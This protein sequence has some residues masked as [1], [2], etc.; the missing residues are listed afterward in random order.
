MGLLSSGSGPQAPSLTVSGSPVQVSA[1]VNNITYTPQTGYYGADT[2]N[3]TVVRASLSQITTELINIRVATNPIWVP[4]AGPFAVAELS[5]IPV[6]F[7]LIVSGAFDHSC[8]TPHIM[9]AG[10]LIGWTGV[11]V[12]G[13]MSRSDL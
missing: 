5:S 12:S 2:L 13:W 7:S 8:Q 9:R 4:P 1:F 10:E 6:P 11:C 3:I